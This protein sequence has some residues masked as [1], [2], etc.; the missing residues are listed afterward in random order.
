MWMRFRSVSVGVAMNVVAMGMRMRVQDF[1]T[2]AGLSHYRPR[3]THESRDIHDAEKDQHQCHGKLH[4]QAN[5]CWDHHI[6]KNDDSA[7]YEDRQ[8]VAHTPECACQSSARELPLAR[9]NCGNGYYMVGVCGMAHAQKKTDGDNR[10]KAG[11]FLTFI[12]S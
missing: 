11:H 12:T 10:K 9:N 2:H 1:R 3:R 4:A 5:A 8:R 6:K 7:H